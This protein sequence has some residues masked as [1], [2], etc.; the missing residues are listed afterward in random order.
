MKCYKIKE[1]LFLLVCIAFTFS[2]CQKTEVAEIVTGNNWDGV[3]ELS[4]CNYS[5]GGAPTYPC[6]TTVVHLITTAPDKVKIYWPTMSAYANPAFYNGVF[7]SLTIQE[8][9]YTIRPITNTVTVQ[10]TASGAVTFYTMA[11]NGLNNYDPVTKT[12]NVKFGYSYAVP[13]VFDAACREW[14]QTI[15]YT[16]PR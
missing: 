6:T 16:G 9:E 13:G 2:A 11:I 12:F 1:R 3:Y 4:F 10:N 7:T 8:P 14:T 15:K 5:G